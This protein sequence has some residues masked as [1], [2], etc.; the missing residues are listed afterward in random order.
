M[1]KIVKVYLGNEE[2][3]QMEKF[4]DMKKNI[5]KFLDNTND[6]NKNKKLIMFARLYFGDEYV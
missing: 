3:E 1:T 4:D 6:I 5:N 2:K